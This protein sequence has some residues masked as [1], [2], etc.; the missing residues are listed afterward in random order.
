MNNLDCDFQVILVNLVIATFLLN[1]G[2]GVKAIE[3]CK[4]CLIFLTNEELRKKEKKVVN[5]G[6]IAMYTM[7]FI[8]YCLI[9]D[10]TNAIKQGNQLLDISHERGKTGEDEGILLSRLAM[11]Y[12]KLLNCSG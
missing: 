6:S 4:E 5:L 9:P 7:I 10:Y 8:A 2:R 11:I 1:T 3:V 12:E